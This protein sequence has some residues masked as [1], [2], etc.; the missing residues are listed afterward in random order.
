M[1]GDHTDSNSFLLSFGLRPEDFGRTDGP[2]E[3]DEGF[4]YEAWKAKK[5]AV[6]PKCEGIMRDKGAMHIRN[7]ESEIARAMP[8]RHEGDVHQREDGAGAT[9]PIPV[10]FGALWGLFFAIPIHPH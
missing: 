5:S 10:E 7:G 1:K 2:I 9:L 3:S 4:I 6:C 8:K